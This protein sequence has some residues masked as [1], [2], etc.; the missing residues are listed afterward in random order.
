MDQVLTGGV[1]KAADSITFPG[2]VIVNFYTL[3]GVGNCKSD[4]LIT[5]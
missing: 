5:Q 1:E 3:F 4:S 2:V